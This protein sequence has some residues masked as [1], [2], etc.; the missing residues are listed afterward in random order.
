VVAASSFCCAATNGEGVKLKYHNKVLQSGESIKFI[1]RLHWIIYKR[2]IFFL[3]ISLALFISIG[4]TDDHKSVMLIAAGISTVFA[5]VSFLQSWFV[6]V[7]TEI[8]VT[9]RRIIH[10]TGWLSR[11]TEEAR[12]Y[13]KWVN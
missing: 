12:R 3:T 11:H 10:K 1:G 9:D 7:T 2:S 5:V 4:V 6:R 13:F 8:V